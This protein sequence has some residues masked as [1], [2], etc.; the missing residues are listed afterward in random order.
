ML[1]IAGGVSE[2]R[3]I[4][5]EWDSREKSSEHPQEAMW[6]ERAVHKEFVKKLRMGI[7]E[8]GRVKVG[9]C[10]CTEQPVHVR[11]S[12]RREPPMYRLFSLI[13]GVW[14]PVKMWLKAQVKA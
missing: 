6:T 1:T 12:H 14:S 7:S 8:H 2:A 9:R 5:K 13:Q 10:L 11:C 3:K 4:M